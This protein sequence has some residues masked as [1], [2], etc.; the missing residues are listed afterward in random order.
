MKRTGVD[1]YA[2]TSFTH[3][4]SDPT[5]RGGLI[6]SFDGMIPTF[7][8][9]ASFLAKTNYKV[10]NDSANGPVQDALQTDKPFFAILQENARLGSAFNDFMT[11]YGKA[12]P[13]WTDYYPVQDRLLA[14]LLV[15][16]TAVELG[17]S[18]DDSANLR[19]SR[20]VVL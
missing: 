20:N 14:V 5:L 8:H 16:A 12:R 11:G 2:A 17:R 4:T 1:S 9:L 10:P 13:S 15:Q 3:A 7:H 18:L 6:Y 19:E